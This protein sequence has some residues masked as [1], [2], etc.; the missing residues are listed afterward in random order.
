MLYPARQTR[1]SQGHGITKARFLIKKIYGLP[2]NS[3][4][5]RVCPNMWAL[6]QS[7]VRWRHN[8]IFPAWWLLII[9]LSHKDWEIPN[10]WRAYTPVMF[11]GENAAQKVD[12]FLLTTYFLSK[13]QKP[14]ENKVQLIAVGKQNV[15]SLQ[16]SYQF[17]SVLYKPVLVSSPYNRHLINRA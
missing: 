12:Y 11:C 5:P 7:L 3:P 1:A 17:L 2:W 10:S 9:W 6:A 16:V 14:D 8:Q 4:P 13:C 15:R